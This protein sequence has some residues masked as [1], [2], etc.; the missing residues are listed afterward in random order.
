MAAIEC[1]QTRDL[2]ARRRCARQ[3]NASNASRAWLPAVTLS[4]TCTTATIVHRISP[5]TPHPKWRP[6]IK[7]WENA[8]PTH[9]LELRSYMDSQ[10]SLREILNAS[11]PAYAAAIMSMRAKIERVDMARYALLHR[12]GGVYADQDL[13]LLSPHVLRCAACSS[14]LILPYESGHG[15]SL[16]GQSF[17]ISPPRHPFWLAL[18]GELVRRYDAGCYEPFNTGP[19]AVTAV[20]NTMCPT[21]HARGV[22]SDMLVLDGLLAGPIALHHTT[23]TWHT[24]ESA[25]RRVTSSF[26]RTMDGR[27]KQ[28]RCGASTLT[29]IDFRCVRRR[30]IAIGREME[31]RRSP[32]GAALDSVQESD[33]VVV[34]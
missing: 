5:P 21:M 9:R 24:A 4:C 30:T 14:R 17:L 29:G 20:L 18:I 26:I 10:E 31:R 6:W 11:V 3:S 32:D 12:D 2:H 28:R 15:R 13:E 23:R 19:D 1:L 27:L 33:Y 25:D 22:A 8:A 16:V 7:T 34:Q